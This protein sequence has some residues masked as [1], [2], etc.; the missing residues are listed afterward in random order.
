[1]TNLE[2]AI[3]EVAAGDFEILRF[4]SQ[5]HTELS[6]LWDFEGDTMSIRESRAEYSTSP[7]S[8]SYSVSEPEP[9]SWF[10]ALT[11]TFRKAISAVDKKLQGRIMSAVS[12]LSENPTS[13]H[14]DTRRPLSGPLKGYWRYRL[15]DY[16][17][18]Y[19]PKEAQRVVRLLDFAA[20]GGI[21]E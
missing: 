15:G 1:M 7:P 20:R 4:R 12:E 17:L 18:V 16:R 6:R 11:P 10:I 21:Y 13:L 3:A 14:G 5:I 2:K 9:L 8:V 19:E